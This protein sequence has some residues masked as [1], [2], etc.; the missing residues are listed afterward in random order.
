MIQVNGLEFRIGE[1]TL[2]SGASFSLRAGEVL[3]VVGPNGA[4]KSTLLKCL[5]GE[6]VPT[7]GSIRAH[8][9]PLA[10]EHHSRM[11][12]WRGVLPQANRIPFA[13]SV[14]EIVLLGRSPHVLGR[15]SE[16]DRAI[17]KQ[18]LA[19]TDATHLVGRSVQT[20]SGGELQRVHMA[21]VLAQ[22]WDGD[23]QF[24]RFLLL[25]E[26][27]SALDL[28]HQHA[29]LRLVREWADKASA[30]LI[31]LHDLNLAARYADF[32]L[33]L[34]EGRQSALGTPQATLT[35]QRIF[36]VFEVQATV[37]VGPQ[38]RLHVSIEG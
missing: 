34:K 37:D 14:E 2:L 3:A 7:S 31:I 24:G 21:R 16:Q 9:Q 36:E 5:S 23:P 26:P 27:T 8:G 15:E 13:F 33:W 17:V 22:V 35:S 6:I 25:D 11:A 28:K 38:G 20:L 18:A 10:A 1:K 32:L 30:I 12:C 4:G 29:L 19:A